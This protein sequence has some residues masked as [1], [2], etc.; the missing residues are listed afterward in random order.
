MF[1][2]GM[3]IFFLKDM[4]PKSENPD[5]ECLVGRPQI[6]E[7]WS[8]VEGK[9]VVLE[10]I[11][12]RFQVDVSPLVTRGRQVILSLFC[13]L[14]SFQA[15]GFELKG[16]EIRGRSSKKAVTVLQ[17]RFFVKTLRPELG[18]LMGS[19]LN[20]SYTDTLSYGVR[21][22]LFLTEWI[23][24]EAQYMRTSVSDSADRIALNRLEYYPVGGNG[25]AVSDVIVNPDPEVNAI[26][27]AAEVTANIAPFY[28]KLNLMD[29]LI[30]YSDLYLTSGFST[31]DTQQGSKMA[32]ILGAGQRFYVKKN[33]SVRLD[34]RDRIF[35]ELRNGQNSRRHGVSYD[36][37]ASYFFN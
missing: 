36:L 11:F 30:V 32:F 29:R 9:C 10:E 4:A 27:G 6:A 7:T 25:D 37:G 12:M 2:T 19:F 15:S 18:V 1:Q 34:V 16:D 33:L 31:V 26:L 17:N 35:S 24:I 28:G 13:F 3:P 20:E 22:G 23:G 21:G 8:L 14:L 5:R